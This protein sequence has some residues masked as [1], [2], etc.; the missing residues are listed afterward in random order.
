MKLD[1][2]TATSIRLICGIVLLLGQGVCQ[3]VGIEVS[4]ILV[5][6]GLSLMFGIPLL[7]ELEVRRRNGGRNGS[8]ERSG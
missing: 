4:W 3:V 1:P 8:D 6:A 5:V 7:G 2:Q